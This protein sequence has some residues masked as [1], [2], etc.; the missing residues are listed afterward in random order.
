MIAP[1]LHRPRAVRALRARSHVYGPAVCA[2][3]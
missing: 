3:G 2:P 1:V